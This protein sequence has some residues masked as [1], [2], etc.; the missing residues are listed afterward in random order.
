LA[1]DDQPLG[2]V[3]HVGLVS[4]CRWRDECIAPQDLKH[5]PASAPGLD[6]V[7]QVLDRLA[8]LVRGFSFR[9]A[10]LA[11]SLGGDLNPQ[12]RK[13]RQ[14]LLGKRSVGKCCSTRPLAS[15]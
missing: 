11:F 4:G 14:Y 15:T 5:V 7:T 12:R 13:A 10:Q 1:H 8:R 9:S 6:R 3:I 2:I